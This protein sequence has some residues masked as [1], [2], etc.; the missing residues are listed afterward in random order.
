MLSKL[1]SLWFTMAA[2]V[3]SSH[4]PSGHQDKKRMKKNVSSDSKNSRMH[5]SAL[6]Y[7]SLL[8][9][10]STGG[11]AYKMKGFVRFQAAMHSGKHWEIQGF[12]RYSGNNIKSRESQV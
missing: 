9:Q 8:H 12:C 10:L 7:W 6:S 3:Q 1:Q 4:S 2:K 5:T 11:L